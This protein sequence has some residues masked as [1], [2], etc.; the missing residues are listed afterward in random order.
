M[1]GSVWTADIAETE[2]GGSS[3]PI[4][5]VRGSLTEPPESTR[6]GRSPRSTATTAHGP[7]PAADVAGQESTRAGA[8][9]V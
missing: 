1:T 6:S 7:K 4:P 3:A 2:C 9:A 8:F 5:A